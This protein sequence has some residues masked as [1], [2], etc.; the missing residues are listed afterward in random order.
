MP[1]P[2]GPLT[3]KEA[4]RNTRKALDAATSYIDMSAKERL[5]AKGEL[6]KELEQRIKASLTHPLAHLALSSN[7]I[8]KSKDIPTTNTSSTTAALPLPTQPG[9]QPPVPLRLCS[10]HYV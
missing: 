8:L 5:W 1:T 6:E 4:M 2:S 7:Q 9:S 3:V 10:S